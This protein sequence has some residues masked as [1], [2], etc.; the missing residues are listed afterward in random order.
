MNVEHETHSRNIAP[1]ISFEPQGYGIIP[2]EIN[3]AIK[4]Q[5]WEGVLVK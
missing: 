1:S 5:K 4:L 3:K 2:F